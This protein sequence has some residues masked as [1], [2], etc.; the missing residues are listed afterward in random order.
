MA[1]ASDKADVLLNNKVEL[2]FRVVQ[3]HKVKKC[4]VN[5]NDGSCTKA[6]TMAFKPQLP[7]GR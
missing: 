1:R 2:L 3:G 5:T 4:Q 7:L 6:S